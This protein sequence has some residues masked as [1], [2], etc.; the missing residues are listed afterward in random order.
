MTTQRKRFRIRRVAVVG[1]VEEEAHNG[2]D[3]LCDSHQ[4]ELVGF[5]ALQRRLGC[6][7]KSMKKSSQVE[8]LVLLLNFDCVR[9]FEV[10]SQ[11][12]FLDA[13]E[14]CSAQVNHESQ[15][16]FPKQRKK[17][18]SLKYFTS[19]NCP[20]VGEDDQPNC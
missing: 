17:M 13:A 14:M 2:C 15:Y 10:L 12:H 1:V 11:S 7:H 4:G 9:C 19:E 16:S 8:E 5:D 18:F 6:E 3:D 20:T